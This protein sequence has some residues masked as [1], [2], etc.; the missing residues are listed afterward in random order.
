MGTSST[1]ALLVR[2]D[3]GIVARA[4]SGFQTRDSVSLEGGFV[5]QRTHAW[6]DAFVDAA[7]ACC[8]QCDEGNNVAAIVFSG[9]MQ[10]TV[11][12]NRPMCLL[13]SD[14]RAE[15]QASF[16]ENILQRDGTLEH[17][18]NYKG[19][20]SVLAKWRY[21]VDNEP[22]T[23]DD[24]KC[25]PLLFGAHS[26]VANALCPETFVCDRTT[27]ATTGLLDVRTN[28]W[29]KDAIASCGLDV[30]LLPELAPANAVLGTVS[31]HT[32]ERLG[33]CSS[34]IDARVVQGCGDLGATTLGAGDGAYI[35]L[36]TS[37]WIATTVDDSTPMA[38]GVYDVLHPQ[39]SK[40][41]VA[42]SMTTT[43]GA[44]A[45]AASM[46]A[47][48]SLKQL[49]NIASKADAGCGGVIFMP[50]LAGERSP[51][52]DPKVHLTLSCLLIP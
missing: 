38:D 41:I 1:K 14:T 15:K 37:G 31:K 5:E 8:S 44:A 32:A 43:G 33:L 34:L 22:E 46:F 11:V 25:T 6:I 10:N 16:C 24:N 21:L 3:A 17:L 4:S 40:R 13:Y 9:T 51:F 28:D 42:A 19:A 18:S 49:D 7:N 12:K 47:G 36:G 30:K 39:E 29:A 50:H 52:L 26:F 35:Y 27:A 45:W 2:Q 20:A 48:G 23:L